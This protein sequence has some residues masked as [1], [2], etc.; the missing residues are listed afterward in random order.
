[1]S[2]VAMHHDEDHAQGTICFLA[3]MS[4]PDCNLAA[5]R[6]FDFYSWHISGYIIGCLSEQFSQ[7]S[8]SR[9]EVGQCPVPTY[10][11]CLVSQI[12]QDNSVLHKNFHLIKDVITNI[13][14]SA[15]NKPNHNVDRIQTP[16]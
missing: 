16:V 11:Y 8:Q 13:T 5:R 12:S 9:D 7:A 2:L 3:P 14:D 10:I 1:M 4:H 6:F 15:T